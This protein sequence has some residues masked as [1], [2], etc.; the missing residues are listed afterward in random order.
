MSWKAVFILYLFL[1]F[2]ATIITTPV[3]QIMSAWS[4]Q[5]AHP[6]HIP[7]SPDQGPIT[8]ENAGDRLFLRCERQVSLLPLFCALHDLLPFSIVRISGA[9]LLVFALL[10]LPCCACCSCSVSSLDPAQLSSA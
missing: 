5:F 3:D 2:T 6:E 8:S 4:L 10:V 1:R 9:L 7:E